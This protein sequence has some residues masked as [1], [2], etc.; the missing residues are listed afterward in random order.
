[1]RSR[2][3]KKQLQGERGARSAPG[4]GRKSRQL[5][6]AGDNPAYSALRLD[7][8]DLPSLPLASSYSTFWP[9][10]NVLMPAFSTAEICTNTS[11]EPSSASMNP[12]P[13]VALN[14]FTVP[15]ATNVS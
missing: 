1:M 13:F 14:H 4:V 2:A 5:R 11:F 8:D 15:V 3:G 9:S 10:F 7:A 6:G 12:N